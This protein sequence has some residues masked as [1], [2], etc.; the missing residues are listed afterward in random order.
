MT[1]VNG[2]WDRTSSE[3]GDSSAE[4]GVKKSYAYIY[5]FTNI[6]STLASLGTHPD[7]IEY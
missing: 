6:Q 5:L 2:L 3:K 4:A 1:T 7:I